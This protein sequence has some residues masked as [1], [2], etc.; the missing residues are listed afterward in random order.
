MGT[1]DMFCMSDMRCLFSRIAYAYPMRN[2]NQLLIR[3]APCRPFS[4][5]AS[6]GSRAHG[7]AMHSRAGSAIRL[8]CA[9]LLMWII[10]AGAAEAACD[11]ST[12]CEFQFYLENDILSGTDQNYTNGIKFGGG[13]NADRMIDR[14]LQSPARSTLR[15]ITNRLGEV[16]V[17][18]FLGQNIYT[19]RVI[20]E[21]RPQPFDRPWAAWLYVGGVA[22]SV[23]DNRLQTVE[24]DIG[25]VGPAALGKLVQ[26][27]LHSLFNADEPRGWGNQL[28]NEPG[29]LLAYLEKWRYGPASPWAMS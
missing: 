4:L 14:L 22:Q 7:L 15:T 23:L 25:M 2:F 8:L 28:R 20:T 18:L 5:R 24:L 16:H 1:D 29:V 12:A 13:V 26:T 21:S 11:A 10:P 3:L 6:M 9:S 19:P 27:E 17:G